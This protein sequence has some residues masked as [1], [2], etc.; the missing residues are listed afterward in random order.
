M[1]L[2]DI[3][4]VCSYNLTNEIPFSP[5]FR[6]WI[7]ASVLLIQS[8]IPTIASQPFISF[9]HP[10]R[11]RFHEK[12]DPLLKSLETTVTIVNRICLHANSSEHGCGSLEKQEEK[13]FKYQLNKNE[14]ATYSREPM[15]LIKNEITTSSGEPTQLIILQSILN[16]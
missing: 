7:S 9:S 13:L 2:H 1:N 11:N 6:S 15:Q 3:S 12:S 5:D 10:T 8:H 16:T 4:L 14:I